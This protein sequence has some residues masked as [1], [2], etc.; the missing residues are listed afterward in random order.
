MRLTKLLSILLVC[1]TLMSCNTKKP[2][3]N[4]NIS[5]TVATTTKDPDKVYV[6][7][8]P[9]GK[10]EDH[11]IKEENGYVLYSPNGTLGI[12]IGT[13][14][15]MTYSVFQVRDGKTTEWV[16]TS[17][18][19]V[20][21]NS[22]RY[23]NN[24]TVA[25]AVASE[26]NVSYP[27]N[28]NQRTAEG[29]CM[30]AVLTLTQ[31]DITYS[32]EVRAYDN[33]VA[34]RYSL[35][36]SKVNTLLELTTYALRK[37]VSQCWYGVN[38]QDYEAVIKAYSPKEA[39][40]DKITGPL[41]A[42]VKSNGGYISIMEAALTDSYPGV[43]LRAEGDAIYSTCF[44]TTP[45]VP[46]GAHV[47]GWRLI[48]V[49]DDLNGLVNNYNV[50]T[51]NGA[52]DSELFADTSWIETGRSAWSWCTIN[53]KPTYEN[54]MRFTVAA[55]LLGYEYNIIDDGWP[56]WSEYQKQLE[57]LGVAG[58]DL[59]VK[60]I[61][62]CAVTGGT[63]GINK[64]PTKSDVD[65]YLNLL[66][67]THMYGAKMDFWWSEANVDTTILQKYTLSEAAKRQMVID[68]HGCN[69]NSGFDV[70][71][72]NELTREGIR[73]LEVFGVSI[74]A[75]HSVYAEMINSQ[76][77]TRYLCGH[78]DWTPS[79]YNAMQIASL[80]LIDSPLMVVSTHP[81]DILASPACEFI[82]S[83]PTTWD[84]TVVLS[85][86][87]IG[88]YSVYAKENNGTWFVGGIASTGISNAKVKLGEFL[89]AGTYTAEV[90]LDGPNGME[91]KTLTVTEKDQIELG[92]LTDGRGF[93]IRISKL[94]LS[95]YGGATGT[96]AVTAPAGATVKYTT[97]GSDPLTS[98]TAVVASGTITVSKS[99][100]L[101]V[102]IADGDG[103]GTLLSYQFNEIDPVY[104]ANYKIDHADN[105]TTV[106]F[107]ADNGVTVY[108]TT[109][110]TAPTTS[111]AV[112]DAPLEF[113][114]SCT[115]R[116]LAVS[117][118]KSL[119]SQ[120]MINIL[121]PV[122]APV[123]DLA[124][125]SAKPISE[126]VTWGKIYYD[127]SMAPSNSMSARPISL[128]GTTTENGTKFS[129]GIS[130]NSTANITYAVPDGYTRFV[131]VV[132]IDNCVFNN[133]VDCSRG[134]STVKIA[135]DG[136]VVLE[137]QAFR[138]GEFVYIDVT[139]PEN[140]KEMTITFTDGGN[141]ATCDNVS[142]AMPGWVK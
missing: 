74:N 62:W 9:P 87:K 31:A 77:Y 72:P 53:R 69:Q 13:S 4:G 76:L 91:T 50:Y 6:G 109:D 1:T 55:A 102:A 101:K 30:Q 2:E 5:T 40:E 29:H 70:T 21:I 27:L 117:S 142:M 44:Y 92:K 38:N 73:G 103:K 119:T 118:E 32:L 126:N 120:I 71:Y 14:E 141:G 88:Q 7:A 22:T 79:T 128:G 54:M 60:Q 43:N 116:Y 111:S 17:E 110:G 98:S 68:F 127:T 15:Q 112:A 106:T 100:R 84:R 99:C 48:N 65:K 46:A 12:R 122:T 57:A 10:A 8:I 134:K 80:I 114:E 64:L 24:A 37:D 28:G 61:L 67:A 132:G 86:S 139:I 56:S 19:G 90:W 39:S 34:F 97:D 105:K 82:K 16:R 11:L 81:D 140:A 124:L 51:V 83:I 108:Y 137:T 131:A 36:S 104:T 89:P 3:N 59:N 42:V 52:P 133:A 66:E 113:T 35:P 129:R 123:S 63:S 94:S 135:F 18:L 125:T 26:I 115:L 58:E 75:N 49:A 138:M 25:S 41:T 47:S 78:A 96:I 130:A 93:A 20:Q 107:T 33:G 45:K 85:C 95:R 136:K 121:R 23:Y